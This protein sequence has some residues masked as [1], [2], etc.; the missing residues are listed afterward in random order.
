MLRL[1]NITKQYADGRGTRRVLDGLELEAGDGEF[2][3][4][5]GESG[6]GKTTLLSILGTILTPDEGTY[7]LGDTE[8]TQA[9]DKLSMIRNSKIGMVFQDHRLLPQLTA[10]QNILLPL[11][12]EKDTVSEEAIGRA[13]EL[14]EL[15]GI[16]PLRDKY[17]DTL[18]GGEKTRVAI[19]RALINKPLLLLADEPTGQLDAGNAHLVADLFK[20]INASLHTTIIMV[21]HSQSMADVADKCYKLAEG[22]LLEIKSSKR[23]ND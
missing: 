22:K 13:E 21:T 20:K 10:I 2:I 18:S 3:A 11:L 12:A 17:V 19:C 8:I 9:T 15:V 1:N 23:L 14:M 16:T 5:T 4:V 7:V 6:S